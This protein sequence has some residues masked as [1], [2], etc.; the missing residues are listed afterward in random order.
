MH[1]FFITPEQAGEGAVT[2]EGPDVNHI[3][4]V[5]RMKAGEEMLVSDGTGRDYLCV[6]EGVGE[7]EVTARI[8][9]EIEDPKELSSRIWLFQGLPKGDKMELIVQ[10]AVELGAAAIVPVSTKNAVVKLDP[11]KAEAKI[12]RWQ[13]IA[14]SAAKQSKR[15]LIPRVEGLMSLKEAFRFVREQG[16]SQCLIPYEHQLGMEDTRKLLAAIGPGQDIAV[17]I[18]PE[19]GFDE[20]EV[21]A[22]L[23]MGVCPVSLGR[24]ILRTETAGLA[25]LSVMMMKL[26]GAF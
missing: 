11:K 19:G 14:E 17:F 7:Q 10:K 16:F 4:N 26:E 13:A 24:R 8:I 21:K 6:L 3:K 9:E 18:G 2:I 1:H 25:I 12:R 22:A 20:E 5:L 15:S 23:E